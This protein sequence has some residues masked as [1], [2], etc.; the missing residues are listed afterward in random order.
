M[1]A[2]LVVTNHPWVAVTDKTGAFSIRGLPA[3]KYVF[4]VW[5]EKGGVLD[6]NL[7]VEVQAGEVTQLTLAYPAERFKE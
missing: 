5:H 1:R 7:V 3:G 6:R 2:W 4:R